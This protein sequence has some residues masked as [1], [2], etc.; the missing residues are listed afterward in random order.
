M[1]ATFEEVNKEEQD[2]E[3]G[4]TMASL[5]SSKMAQG[6]EQTP[7]PSP[8][9]LSDELKN[10]QDKKDMKAMMAEIESLR[11]K[12]DSQEVA[13]KKGS[14]KMTVGEG[15]SGGKNGEEDRKTGGKNKEYEKEKSMKGKS[16]EEEESESDESSDESSEEESSTD[17]EISYESEEE[18]ELKVKKRKHRKPMLRLRLQEPPKFD[19]SD[20]TVYEEFRAIFKEGYGK[21]S[22]LTS[23]AKL[24]QLKACLSGEAKDLLAGLQLVGE[25]YKLALQI[26]DENY[27]ARTKPVAVLDKKFRK[28]TIHQKDYK[29]MKKDVSKLIAIVYDM[30][31]RGVAVDMPYIYDPLIQKFPPSIAE[32]LAIKVQSSKFKGDFRKLQKWI[33]KILNAKISTQER[34]M[35][36]KEAKDFDLGNE[37]NKVED[38]SG[39]KKHGFRGEGENQKGSGKKQSFE[40][41]FHE[42]KEDNKH[43]F[44]KCP[45]APAEKFRLARVGNRCLLCFSSS[46]YASHCDK[47]RF[48]CKKCNRNH[49]TCVHEGVEAEGRERRSMQF[50]QGRQHNG[51]PS[52][53]HGQNNTGFQPGTHGYNTQNRFQQN[54]QGSSG[55]NGF[56]QKPQ[57]SGNAS[58][59][60]Q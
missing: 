29:Q 60:S 18:E 40:C 8:R 45:K 24:I 52:Q 39:R 34:R 49:N 32:Q 42:G 38:G 15:K 30:K 6:E 7:T 23:V 43:P 11:K 26:L 13:G 44:W 56:Q 58:S 35:E 12:V 36:L 55:Q 1:D 59:G 53:W 51:Q 31:N 20:S 33:E 19:G 14:Q 9:K 54:Q 57:W 21:R 50:F 16:K 37:A 41:V 2:L 5:A 22:D 27:L 48:K 4:E 28:M 3:D 46:H 47:A 25:N 10:D 17:T